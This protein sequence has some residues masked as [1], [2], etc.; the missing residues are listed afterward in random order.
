MQNKPNSSKDKT[1]ATFF[2]AKVYQIKP[3]LGESKKQTQS[4]PNEPNFKMG[5]INISTARTKAYAKEQ[6]TMNNEQLFKT[7]PI[8][9]NSPPAGRFAK[10]SLYP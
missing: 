4:N 10:I 5:N 7:N 9:P 3:P 8:E 1:N 6:R 2:V